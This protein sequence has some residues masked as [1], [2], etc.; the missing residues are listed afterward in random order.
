MSIFINKPKLEDIFTNRKAQVVC[1][2]TVH[3]PAVKR[4]WWED[5]DKNELATYPSGPNEM[6]N[7]PSLALDITYDEW[8]K[9]IRRYCFV[10]HS[11]LL[12]PQ[13]EV[14]E[15]SVGEHISITSSNILS[16]PLQGLTVVSYLQKEK[17]SALQC[18]CCLR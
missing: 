9:G 14:Y 16:V 18:S 2:V 10:E 17:L 15:R 4:I 12:E 6:K 7:S 5:E 13:Y 11:Q 8:S 1:K 3:T